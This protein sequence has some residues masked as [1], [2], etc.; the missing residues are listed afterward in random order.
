MTSVQEPRLEESGL[1]TQPAEL[2]PPTGG[3]RRSGLLTAVRRTWRQLTSMRTALLLLFL[4]ALASV[5]GGFLPQRS[6]NPVEVRDWFAE[7]PRLAPLLDRLSLFDVFASPWF[8]A[9]YLLLFV[10]LVGCIMPRARL[11]LRAL[12]TP[13]PAVPAALSRLPVSDRWETDLPPEQ[14]RAAATAALPRWRRRTSGT[15]PSAGLS[16]EKGYLRETGNLL[17][18]VSL[19]ALLVGVAL[20]GLYG[21]KGTVLVKEGDGFANAVFNYDD[22]TPGRRFDPTSLAPFNVTLEDFRATYG[23][24]GA[25]RTFDA[26]LSW[27]PGPDAPQR[28]YDL[29]V[30]SPLDVG[31]GARLYLIGHGYAPRVV[32]RGADDEVALR[33]SVPCLP[34]DANFLS[35]CVL[36][37]PD[38][39]PEQLAFEGILTPTTVQDPDTG[40]VTSVHPAAEVPV[41]TLVGYRGDL[42]L[43]AGTPASVYSIEDKDRLTQVAPQAQGLRPGQTWQVPGGGSITYEGTDEW[44]TFQITQDPGKQLVLW[45]SGVLVLGLL[46]SLF[47]RRRRVWVRA[48]ASEAGPTVVEVGGLARSDSEAF[49][50]EF[51]ELTERLRERTGARPDP[52]HPD[53]ARPDP[54]QTTATPNARP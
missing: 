40:Q 32:V 49:A 1:S 45:A 10:S 42:G 22:I 24:D 44:V 26:L 2:P 43:D 36:K 34:Q 51:V 54:D 5:P 31:G 19:V 35:S 38:A 52:A 13:P 30:N 33:Q 50:R 18:H 41:L 53:D 20:G 46:L 15:G 48:A 17:F 29:R 3:E 21:F 6:L 4:L 16:A 9:V 12:R 8:A 27:S 28:P 25:A 7:H 11:H 39:A 37:A 23:D 47:V 14:V